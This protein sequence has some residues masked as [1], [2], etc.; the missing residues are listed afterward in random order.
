M[1][2]KFDVGESTSSP[3]FTGLAEIVRV[4]RADTQALD[5]VYYDTSARDLASNRITLRR[6]TGGDDAGWHL[7]LPA[8]PDA[9][10][11][12][13]AALDATNGDGDHAD[14]PTE[15]LDVVLAIVRDRPVSPVARIS[16]TRQVHLLYGADDA[17]LAEFCDD[18]VI[19]GRGADGTIAEQRWREWE[20]ELVGPEANTELM[21]K[22]SDRLLGAGAAPA[23]HGSKLA[24]VLGTT[25]KA[26]RR[27]P[28]R[29]TRYIGQSP[30][31]STSCWCGTARCA[32][33]P[34][35][36]CTRCG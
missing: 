20:L 12:V 13:R 36:P 14:V 16:T 34:T 32:P 29:P 21:D 8:G 4:E 27:L 26:T 28:A 19:A 3:S 31:S 6:R 5:A 15:L 30:S 7:K 22:L 25:P 33:R 9:R 17:V 18:R 2:R 24:R 35:T 23:R 11:E 10:T 1:E